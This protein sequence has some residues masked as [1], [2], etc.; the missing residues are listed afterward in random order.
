MDIDA[1]CRRSRPRSTQ[2]HHDS[3]S[4]TCVRPQDGVSRSALICVGESLA[5]AAHPKRL[6]ASASDDWV[7]EHVL[8]MV[9]HV[10]SWWREL[11]VPQHHRRNGRRAPPPATTV[12]PMLCPPRVRSD[13]WQRPAQALRQASARSTEQPGWPLLRGQDALTP[14]RWLA[15]LHAHKLNRCWRHRVWGIHSH[16]PVRSPRLASSRHT[17]L[18]ET[19]RARRA[20]SAA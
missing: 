11:H 3:L 1:A 4:I 18:I 12:P 7:Q 16:A 15:W 10:C 17:R 19:T 2:L 9:G 13:N 20:L 5:T 14:L 6:T 8:H